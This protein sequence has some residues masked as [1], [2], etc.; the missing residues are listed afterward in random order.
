MKVVEI[1]KSIDGE[2]KRVGLPTTFVRLFGCNL[3]CKYCDTRYG[4]EGDEYTVMSIAQVMDQVRELG[5]KSVTVTGGEPLI[6]PGIKNLIKQLLDD[7]CW[8]NIETN[9]TVDV[10]KFRYEV[11]GDVGISK[12][13][14]TVD[15]KCPCSGMEDKMRLDMYGKLRDTDVIKFVV[16]D[17]KDMD[18]ALGVLEHTQTRAE[19]YFSPVFGH[20]EASSI[21]TY[22]LDHK[23]YSCKVQV[24]LHK[25]LWSPEKRGV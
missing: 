23:L 4:C 18:V 10:D 11:S 7:G 25:M 12:L 9:G 5:I 1:F 8:V 21:V 19:V 2:G 15:Y 14:F 17:K 6:H 3:K 13:F 16:G 24:Q 22:I 20:I